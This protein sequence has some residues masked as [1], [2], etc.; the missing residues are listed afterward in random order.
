MKTQFQN[1]KDKSMKFF[2]SNMTKR[3]Y[4][5]VISFFIFIALAYAYLKFATPQY[6]ILGV[7]VLKDEKSL[8]ESKTVASYA[9][10]NGLSF[11]INPSENV[12]NEIKV[13]TSRRL[14]KEVVKKLSLNTTI[15]VR[16]GLRIDEIYGEEVPFDVEIVNVSTDSIKERN[17]EVEFLS[18]GMVRVINEEEEYDSQA[19][20]AQGFKTKQFD[21]V[22]RLKQSTP[23]VGQRYYIN[24]ISENAAANKLLGNYNVELTDKGATTVN[25]QLYYP[26]S[27]RGE[28]VLQAIMDCYM[29]NNRAEKVRMADSTLVFIDHRLALVESELQ[30]VEKNL[31]QFRSNNKI[32]DIAEQ[33]KMLVGN[34][35]EYYNKLKYQ[36][37]QLKIVKDLESYVK[38]TIN[39]RV[40]SSLNIQNASFASSLQQYNGLL[41]EY[42][43][44]KLSYTENNPVIKN[45]REQIQAE[46]NNLLQSVASYKKEIQLSSEGIGSL[47]R[48][49]NNQISQVPAKE[50]QFVDFS[51]Q[52]ALKQQLYVYL[53]QKREEATIAKTSNMQS[54]SIVDRAKSSNGPVKPIPA[55]IYLMSMMMGLI[56]PFGYLNARELF[57]TRLSSESDIEK[58]TDIEI[59]GKI[60][61]NSSTEPLVIGEN[62]PNTLISEGFRSLRANLYYALQSKPSNVIM[63]TSSIS[64]EGKTF[65]SW[66]LGNVLSMT[67]KKVVF[68]EL[69]L[70]KPKLATMMGIRGEIVGFSD[71]IERDAALEDVLIPCGPNSNSYLLS[72]GTATENPSELLLSEKMKQLFED[73]RNQFDYVIVDSPPV[74]LVSDALLIQ[75]YVELTIFVCRHNYTRKEQFEFINELKKKN[76]LSEMYLV[77][78][79][80]DFRDTGYYG[81]GYGYGYDNPIGKRGWPWGRKQ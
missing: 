67:G 47:N 78:N 41:L 24:V 39:S 40:P 31:E 76:K 7:M 19:K 6:E 50:R 68:V 32:T 74:G 65:M 81:Y 26:H 18:G 1:D 22:F 58:Y 35:S 51:R 8:A 34:A 43:K 3:W 36:E 79:D 37:V 12:M 23:P 49:F 52:Q 56:V 69:D 77:V 20:I 57:R 60:G 46:R 55:I 14:A 45:L 80:V 2:I 70:R 11:L 71:V 33:S 15:G 42:E 64:G 17:F 4:V 21:I 16:N 59:I 29:L 75:Q 66:N 48:G 5:F 54:A 10:D 44:K 28:V 27:K 53:L 30:G 61:H 63:V 72:A 25:M 62:R 73:L 9:N 38:N 13:L